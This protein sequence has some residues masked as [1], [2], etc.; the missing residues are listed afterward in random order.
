MK[1][2]IFKSTIFFIVAIICFVA[3]W[4]ILCSNRNETMRLPE[5]C[6]IVFL[7]NSHME[8]AINDTILKNSFN[9]GRSA[10]HMEFIYCKIK[11]LKRYNPQLDT[12]IIGYDN[13]ILAQHSNEAFNTAL[14]SP[15][16][17]DTYEIEDLYSLCKYSSFSYIES[18]ITHPFNWFKLTQILK[19]YL[20]EK[21]SI[22]N[23]SNM[24]G[25][26]YLSRDKLAEHINLT[27]GKSHNK[28]EYEEL[29]IYFLN[30]IIN[31]CK[32]NCITLIFLCP[33]QHSKSPLDSSF[34]REFHNDYYNNIKFYDFKVFELPDS[35]FGDLNHLNYK[36]AR[37]FSEYLEKEVFHKNNYPQ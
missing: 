32:N 17:Y 16:Y 12:V 3:F 2:F 26:L 27:H 36:G 20:D 35:C 6:N 24:G 1:K 4:G 11:L 23:M 21:V 7:G 37:V 9:F 5:N 8:C 22:K 19:S 30:N 28:D 31:Y 34:Y 25:Y 10:E 33:P 15:Y 13:V 18:H 29:S 14:F